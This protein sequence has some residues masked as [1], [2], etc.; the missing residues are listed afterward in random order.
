MR[1]RCAGQRT[2]GYAVRRCV[3]YSLLDTWISAQQLVG[4]VGAGC[5]AFEAFPA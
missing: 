1:R 3:V 4:F 5:S 2:I